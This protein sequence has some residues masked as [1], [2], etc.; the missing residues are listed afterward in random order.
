MKYE[1]HKKMNPPTSTIC[2]IILV[3]TDQ[4]YS[5]ESPGGNDSIPLLCSKEPRFKPRPGDQLF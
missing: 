4:K 2:C 5:I 1:N 3:S